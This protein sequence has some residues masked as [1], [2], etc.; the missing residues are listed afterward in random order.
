M[1]V[2]YFA[3]LT[4]LLLFCG[5]ALDVGV[6]QW[7]QL[8]VQSAADAAAQEGMYQRA[9]SDSAWATAAQTQATNNG[10]TNGA[11]NVSVTLS[12]PPSSGLLAGDSYAV[13]ATISQ[14]E[15]NMFMS[16]VN[17]GKSVVSA[18][19]IAREI[20]TCLWV[21]NPTSSSNGSL[22]LASAGLYANCGV[23]VNTSTGYSIAVDGF[24]TLQT[25]RN[26]VVGAATTGSL[27]S[28]YTYPQTTYGAAT[29]T[30]PL[31]YVTA[32][33]F[34]SCTYSN[35]TLSGQ[36]ATAYPGTYCGMSLTGS[37]V[38]MTSGLYIIVG[39]LSISNSNIYGTSGVTFYFTKGGSYNTYN[40]ITFTH[41][42]F[43]LKAPTSS[44]SGGIP[45]IVMFADRNWV[46]HGSQGIQVSY[47]YIEADGIW[48]AL[49]T[50]L[51]SWQN[52]WAC[53]KY[54]G[55]DIDNLYYYLSTIHFATDYSDFS[56]VSPFHYEDG[57]LV[58]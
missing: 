28:G 9:R 41:S 35:F 26:R 46:T 3:I 37:N 10:Y 53:Y 18:T 39:G 7:K 49:N 20:P 47:S 30:D 33:T 56:G 32:P 27:S 19:A 4:I 57:V 8:R 31:N 2:N 23:Y 6:L 29:K 24:A 17:A 13:Q 48:Y 58:Q 1:L 38:T 42:Q 50:G 22:W 16:L 40:N 21:M 51:Y 52:T 54:I 25:L 34:T 11:N 43:Y 45:G 14:T 55:W 15:T 12:N 5:L 44:V 36:T